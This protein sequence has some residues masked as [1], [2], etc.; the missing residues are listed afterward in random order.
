MDFFVLLFFLYMFI[1]SRSFDIGYFAEIIVILLAYC[2]F[3]NVSVRFLYIC[4]I[5]IVLSVF[6]QLMY[7][8]LNFAYPWES[9]EDVKGI[10]YNTGIWGGFVALCS[11]FVGGTGLFLVKR[12]KITLF[13]LFVLLAYFVYESA[14]RAAWL[15]IIFSL[16]YFLYVKYG[17]SVAYKVCLFIG[18][19]LFAAVCFPKIY[20]LKTESAMGRFYIWKTSLPVIKEHCLLG[21]G[22]GGFQVRYMKRQ[23]EYLQKNAMSPFAGLADETDNP[24]NEF[25]KMAVEY[26]ILGLVLFA[27]LLYNVFFGNLS[28]TVYAIIIR[29]VLW[30]MLVFAFFSYPFMYIQFRLL[31]VMCLA[32][33]A[34]NYTD[35][36]VRMRCPMDPKW[37]M[38][39]T[40]FATFP[41]MKY[42]YYSLRWESCV[43]Q[44]SSSE[45]EKI[46]EMAVLYPVLKKNAAFLTY[47]AYLYSERGD[48]T[49]SVSKWKESLN[50]KVSYRQY[51][52]LGTDLERMGK[53]DEAEASWKM[54]SS[55]IPSRFTPLYFQI[56]MAVKLKKYEKADS[57][58]TLFMTK[59]KKVDSPDLERMNVNV[60]KWRNQIYRNW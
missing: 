46:E 56:E 44:R 43:N 25:I 6:A 1:N 60:V 27:A 40:F 51:I 49:N 10:F 22:Q 38:V 3:R 32:G 33:I 36:V 28:D 58:I 13:L 4:F 47:Y 53:Y 55:M 18:F 20:N 34:Y 35:N 48:Y 31:F 21:T 8:W 37:I 17:K 41:I 30:G 59:N 39:F 9:F 5:L 24:F 50:Y 16:F 15:A 57:L 12:Y 45:D 26:G 19:I 23:A 52:S 2:A 29:G 54:A 14:S 42:Y 7:C 11:I